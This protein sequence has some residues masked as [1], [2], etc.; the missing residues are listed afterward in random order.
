[1]LGIQLL[2]IWGAEALEKAKMSTR[3]NTS[4]D[5]SASAGST[6]VS[7]ETFLPVELQELLEKNPEA[8]EF[9]EQY[10]KLKD[11]VPDETVG[12]VEEGQV[13]LLLQWDTAWGYTQYGDSF[14]AVTGCG[15]TC[16]SMVASGLTGDNTITPAEV[17]A[18][19][20]ENGFYESGSGTSWLLMTQ[21]A[22]EFGICGQELSLDENSIV[23]ALNAGMPIICSMRPGD[24]TTTGHFIVLTA[25]QDGMIH[26]NDPNSRIR[27][28]RLWSYDELK[29]KI[30]N[31]WVFTVL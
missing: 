30:R 12:E 14:L 3:K 25:V 7:D 5:I 16:I 31:L 13:P 8:Q 24:F 22:E 29:N 28:E 20:E 17:A 9:V 23:A 6:T 11:A 10:W 21:G 18:Y 27:S 15:P 1:M 4:Q 2:K 19:A 26:V